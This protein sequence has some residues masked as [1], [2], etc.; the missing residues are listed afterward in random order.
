MTLYKVRV[1]W[2][3]RRPIVPDEHISYVIVEADS[4]SSATLLAAQIVA[5]HC[6]MVTS[7]RAIEEG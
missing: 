1:G 2:T 6:T 3:T 4:E 7:S 5:S